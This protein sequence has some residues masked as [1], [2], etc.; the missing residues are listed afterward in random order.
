MRRR[1]ST[2]PREEGVALI[3]VL[4][5]LIL[6]S[7]IAAAVSFENRANDRIAR[8]LADA[9][10]AR[11]AADAGV[12][13]GVLDLLIQGSGS[14]FRPDGTVY[15][16]PFAESTVYVSV[17]DEFSKVNLNQA[18]EAVL[19]SLFSSAGIEQAK[20]QSLADAIADFRDKDNIPR[21]QGAEETDYR[22]AGLDWGPKNASFQTIEELQQ[23]LGMTPQIYERIIP[24]FTIYSAGT[25]N[26]ELASDRLTA[27]LRK[28]GFR[29][30]VSSSHGIAYSITAVAESSTGARFAREATVQV[31]FG[32]PSLIRVLTWR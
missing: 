10:A 16:W 31:L 32:P 7:L 25:V 12:A 21:L 8:N 23:V 13:R 24:D 15:R 1:G 4:W 26:P 20:A 29:N 28:V 2:S 19:S 18:S 5:T 22:A 17:R 27:S 6:L 9:A 30:F 14:D 11:A 3:A